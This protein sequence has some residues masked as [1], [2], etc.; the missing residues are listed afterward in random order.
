M[1]HVTL[2]VR[3]A[4]FRGVVT[5][6]KYGKKTK[7]KQ[8]GEQEEPTGDGT[9][10]QEPPSGDEEDP[11]LQALRKENKEGKV[12]LFWMEQNPKEHD[13]KQPLPLRHRNRMV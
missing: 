3:D 4:V 5:S 10:E 7:K 6:D 1:L 13:R 8:D 2:Q 11:A 12:P 9:E